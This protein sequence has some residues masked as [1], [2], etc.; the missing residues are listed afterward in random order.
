MEPEAQGK[1]SIKSVL[2]ELLRLG[3]EYGFKTK[4][5]QQH[6][7]GE[8]FSVDN[9]VLY[10]EVWLSIF[11]YRLDDAEEDK[12]GE[13]EVPL[14]EI[15]PDSLWFYDESRAEYVSFKAGLT[16]AEMP[17]VPKGKMGSVVRKPAQ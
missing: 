7:C 9:G 14:D 6:Y 8:E 1:L 5:G 4:D 3:T 13:V 10:Y 17:S 2:E 11:D 15:D 16:V 12:E